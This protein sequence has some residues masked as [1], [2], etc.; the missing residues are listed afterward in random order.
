VGDE[1]II[2]KASRVLADLPLCDR[3][4]G[5]L[6][7]RLGYGWSN[8][9]RGDAIKRVIVM[10]LHRKYKLQ[11][12]LDEA[13]RRILLNI[14]RQA[15]PLLKLLK[16]HADTDAQ[17]EPRGSDRVSCAICGGLLDHVIEKAAREG[18]KLLKAYDIRGFVVGAKVD[19]KTRRVEEDIKMRYGLA[20][21]EEIKAEIRR[22]V[23]KLIQAMD[24]SLYA[25]FENPEAT[26]LVEFPT[27]DVA[28]QVNSLLLAG[29][30][31]KKARMISQAYWPSPQGPRYFSVEEA[32][33]GLLRVTGGER[34]VIH[35]AGREDV[36]ARMLGTG[37]PLI[38]EVKAPR[39]RHLDIPVFERYANMLT[40]GLVEFE[41]EGLAKRSDIRLYKEETARFK[42]TYKALIAS[43]DAPLDEDD[44]DKLRR[45]FNNRR[46]IQRTPRRVLHRRA[47]ITRVRTVYTTSC[48]LLGAHVMECII[49]AEGGLYIKEL[50]NG[51]AGRTTPS[52]S[53]VIGK[54]LECAELD[55]ISVETGFD[56]R[57]GA[58]T[59]LGTR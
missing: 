55:V 8:K 57:I 35:A 5:R 26:L 27:G 7:A 59:E 21:G 36:D 49:D 12:V 10:E 15:E 13:D 33:W 31:W 46:V 2:S 32:A 30:Y 53:E 38:I 1:D 44:V 24:K 11:G 29:R 37:R 58:P 19:D 18:V 40:K 41:I 9:E 42:K 20:F 50:I 56:S 34:V 3:C 25:E 39:R 4:L 16:L 52:F 22:E 51:D 43:L 54:S 28:I 6:F 48:R 14:G 17:T 47:D 45:E 23:G